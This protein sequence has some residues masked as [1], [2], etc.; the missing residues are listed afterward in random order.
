MS[1][2]VLT[3]YTDNLPYGPI[4]ERAWKAYADRHGYTFECRRQADFVNGSPEKTY[5]SWHKLQFMLDALARYEWVFWA[6]ADSLPT[7]PSVRISDFGTPER[8]T[9][10]EDYCCPSFSPWNSGLMLAHQSAD[11]TGLF[12]RAQREYAYYR[13]VGYYDQT[14]LQKAD[15]GEVHVLPYGVLWKLP[16]ETRL[17]CD[18]AKF[19]TPGTFSVH[20]LGIAPF[21][22]RG[23]VMQKYLNH[24]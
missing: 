12:K 19:W 5:P 20:C 3:G 4:A 17:T 10:G 1:L 24:E 2:L 6:D 14:A 11:V 16:R 23:E 7:D 22:Q 21:E 8:L 9:V 18:S 15:L 13:N